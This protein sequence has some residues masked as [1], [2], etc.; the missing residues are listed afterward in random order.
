M[1]DYISNAQKKI[2][3]LET[4]GST[5]NVTSIHQNPSDY[6]FRT[7]VFPLAAITIIGLLLNAALTA[8]IFWRRLY[9]NF[10]SSHFIVHVCL[11]NIFGLGVLVPLFLIN[12]W[13]GTN[14][15]GNNNLM[16]RI[17]VIPKNFH[18]FVILIFQ[19]F[20][21]C[22]QW[23]VIHFMALCIA[24]VHLITFAR[25]HYAQ[26][27]GLPPTYLCGLAWI[28]AFGIALPCITNSHIVVYDR[29]LRHCVWGNSNYSYKFLTYILIL[30]VGIP[31]GLSYY[32]Y[33][34]VLKKI[35]HSPLVCQHLG[36]YRSRFLIYAFLAGFV[37]FKFLTVKNYY[38]I[39]D[40][41]FFRPFY[42][43]PFY[44][45]TMSGT[46]RFDPTSP[47]PVL[48]MFFGYAPSLISPILYSLSL[49][50]IKEED[51]AL[52]ARAQK[53]INSY[54]QHHGGQYL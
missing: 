21:M 37:I 9:D 15:W 30:C 39:R 16:C 35:Y 4:N 54:Q 34:K 49:V 45:I 8:H 42:Q 47:I 2:L 25:I 40:L 46:W 52:T 11:T 31:V 17:Q 29:I 14:I 36:V 50:E 10:I 53:T 5:Q 24:G 38:F 7:L 33:I 51:M 12:L 18:N 44:I 22:S 43:I 6:S 41:I 28:T 23:T 19:T 32:A 48:A 27:F 1:E 13:S 20:L 3:L 26:L